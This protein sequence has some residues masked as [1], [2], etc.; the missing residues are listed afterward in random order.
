MAKLDRRALNQQLSEMV[1]DGILIKAS[2]NE[3]LPRVEL[4]ADGAW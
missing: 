3:L 1:N 4:Y 2:F